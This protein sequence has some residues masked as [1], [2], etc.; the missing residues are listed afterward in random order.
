MFY[1]WINWNMSLENLIHAKELLG[2]TLGII[3]DDWSSVV[4]IIG[5]HEL[6]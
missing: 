4:L 3:K 1:V 6:F 5:S 2:I